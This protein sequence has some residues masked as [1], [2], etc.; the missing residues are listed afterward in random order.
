MITGRVVMQRVRRAQ[1]QTSRVS[2]FLLQTVE[3]FLPSCFRSVQIYCLQ[4]PHVLSDALK[5]SSGTA[6]QAGTGFDRR[7]ARVLARISSRLQN[8]FPVYP[9]SRMWAP[10]P[11]LGYGRRARAHPRT[12]YPVPWNTCRRVEARCGRYATLQAE[13]VRAGNPCEVLGPAYVLD[14]AV[15][16]SW[17]CGVITFFCMSLNLRMTVYFPHMRWQ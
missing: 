16:R 12:R 8:L 10:V 9:W 4:Q 13:C 2:R 7:F 1:S 6:D 11:L 15:Q 5:A 17:D 14:F 3:L